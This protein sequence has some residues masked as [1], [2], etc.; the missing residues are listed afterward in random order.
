M[1]LFVT[2]LI[3][4]LVGSLAAVALAGDYPSPEN[5]NLLRHTD[6][7]GAADVAAELT[8][9]SSGGGVAYPAFY[10]VDS[11]YYCAQV[12]FSSKSETNTAS[13][14]I[15]LPAAVSIGQIEQ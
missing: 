12:T 15:T 2:R 6:T 13:I 10:A 8:G 5:V 7:G 11:G 14:R 3:A 4:C 9:I 1:K